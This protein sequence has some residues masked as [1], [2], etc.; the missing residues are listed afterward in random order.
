MKIKCRTDIGTFLEDVHSGLFCATPIEKSFQRFTLFPQPVEKTC[1]EDVGQKYFALED[2][3]LNISTLEMKTGVLA[4]AHPVHVDV[5]ETK[6][7]PTLFSHVL[8][9]MD[10]RHKLYQLW[11]MLESGAKK[12]LP[13]AHLQTWYGAQTTYANDTG[14]INYRVCWILERAT[15]NAQCT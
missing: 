2:D 15:I 7:F 14:V 13:A 3:R 10:V 4:W 9:K 12:I 1:N 8:G 11:M 5:C 6:S